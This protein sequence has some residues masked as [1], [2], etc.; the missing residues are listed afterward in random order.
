MCRLVVWIKDN[1]DP[2]PL[3]DARKFKPGMVV[4]ILEDGIDPGADVWRLGWWRVL[5]MPGVPVKDM[6]YLLGGD[7]DF[8]DARTFASKST[9]PRKRVNMLDVS[10]IKEMP[11]DQSIVT[12]Q[13]A[14]DD[15]T[16]SVLA[17]EN[18]AV[19]GDDPAVIG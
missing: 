2:D 10:R 14:V 9:Y 19:I 12:S 15:V 17:A 8:L 5:D 7:P 4:D 16:L 11:A 3:K 18:A 13:V 6:S 1:D